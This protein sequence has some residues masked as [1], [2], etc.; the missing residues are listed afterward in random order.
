MAGGD[1]L[2]GLAGERLD[3]VAR[4]EPRRLEVVPLEELQQARRPDLAG[5]QAARDVVGGVLA[6]VRAEP[7]CHRV[8]VDAV[9]DE[10][11]LGHRRTSR[12]VV[13]RIYRH[14]QRS[15]ASC[16]N[17]HWADDGAGR[18]DR[19]IRTALL[20][21]VLGRF[22]LGV[23]EWAGQY[24][25]TDGKGRTEVADD[26]AGLWAA[27]ERLAGPAARPARPGAPGRSRRED[28]RRAR[29]GLPRER[30]DDADPRAARGPG[31]RR[32]GGDRERARRDRDR[33]RDP[34]PRRRAHGPA[35]VGLRLLHAPRRPRGRA[36]RPRSTGGRRG[37]IPPF[38]RVV[39][40]TT[41]RRRPGADPRDARL[42]SRSSATSTRSTPSSRPSTPSTGSAAR[43]RS[44]RSRRPTSSS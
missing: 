32:D 4:D 44:G 21:R 29:H 30:Q 10:D 41:G 14:V 34:P 12:I 24:V 42:A 40:E 2:L 38:T 7:A 16:R 43:S 13:A 26:L 31:A 25:V 8:D 18:R 39:V 6:A 20:E 36:A 33:P 37:E 9:R 11:L 15:A 23:R 22:G 3:R 27:A 17:E 1:D 35:R 28:A 5:E 19:V